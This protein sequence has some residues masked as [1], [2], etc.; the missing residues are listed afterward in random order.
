[1]LLRGLKQLHCDTKIKF[2]SR[3]NAIACRCGNA[4]LL[5]N[6]ISTFTTGVQS[7]IHTAVA[8]Q[9]EELDDK[10]RSFEN[11]IQTARKEFD[12][13]HARV[14][15]HAVNSES[16]HAS[17]HHDK[18]SKDHAFLTYNKKKLPCLP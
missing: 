5:E 14:T 6:M 1:M 10:K 12:A 16:S 3:V 7:A 13:C 2:R 8:Y 11:G 4:F 9:T 15:K 18:I 17:L